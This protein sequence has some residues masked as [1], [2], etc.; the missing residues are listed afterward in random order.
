AG[1]AARAMLVQAAARRFGVPASECT[2]DKGV[3][4]HKS[5]GKHAGLGELALDAAALPIPQD[6]RPKD[7]TRFVLL[8]KPQARLDVPPK[9]DGGAQ[10]GVGV[11]LPGFLVAGV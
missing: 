2:V 7:P 10:F 6:A 4:E 3:V 11:R 5:T 8:G 9:G 1:A